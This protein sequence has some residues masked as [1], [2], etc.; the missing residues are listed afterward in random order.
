MAK[1]TREVYTAAKR[2]L[3]WLHHRKHLGVT[4]GSPNISSLS[5]L[6][7]PDNVPLPMHARTSYFLHGCVDS[8]L[9]KRC[10]IPGATM[11]DGSSRSQLGYVIM[12]MGGCIEGVSR[13]QVSTAIDTTGAE[14]F[15][16]STYASVMI[17]IHGVLRFVWTARRAAISHVVR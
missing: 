10:L 8:D 13:R 17:G 1:P 2:I 6:R 15:A 14:L 9:S 7:C 12:F 3:T 11:H 5:D 4:Y 16:L